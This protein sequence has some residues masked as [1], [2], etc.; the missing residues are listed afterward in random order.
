MK[1]TTTFDF[2]HAP[3]RR[4]YDIDAISKA[5][6]DYVNRHNNDNPMI[7]EIRHG[8]FIDDNAIHL[9]EVSHKIKTI[10]N[11]NG[12]ISIEAELLDTPKGK[13]V[14]EMINAGHSISVHPR[15]YSHTEDVIDENGDVIGENTVVDN[16][17]SFDIDI[18][19]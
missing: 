16:I 3:S 4:V 6:N 17:I 19:R 2:N 13:L 12:I 18:N 5:F 9:Q 1:I 14:Q 7:G 8:G 15:I 10:N 11:D